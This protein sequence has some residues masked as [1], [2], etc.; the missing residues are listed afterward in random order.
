MLKVVLVRYWYILQ[1]YMYGV[2]G[3]PKYHIALK[4]NAW[5]FTFPGK[6]PEINFS[7]KARISKRI[8]G[9]LR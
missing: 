1:G 4:K 2:G 5:S 3:M 8:S 9:N 7:Q 6:F